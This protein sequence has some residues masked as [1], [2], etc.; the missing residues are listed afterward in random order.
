MKGGSNQ[1]TLDQHLELHAGL[2]LVAGV[3]AKI[4]KRKM[5]AYL[6]RETKVGLIESV[7]RH[8]RAWEALGLIDWTRGK[9]GAP[10]HVVLL[11]PPEGLRLAEIQHLAPA[12]QLVE[13]VT[14]AS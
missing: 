8:L 9:R 11:F 12:A 10:G 4:A 6:M 1:P 5:D 13:A 14:A 3:G 2:L 7:D